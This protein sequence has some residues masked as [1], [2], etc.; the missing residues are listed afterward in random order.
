MVSGNETPSCM[1]M[2][3]ESD[4][5]AR[6]SYESGRK[7]RR[8]KGREADKERRKQDGKGDQDYKGFGAKDDTMAAAKEFKKRP[9]NEVPSYGFAVRQL[10]KRDMLPAI[11]FIFS[12]MRTLSYMHIHMHACI[13]KYIHT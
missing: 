7:G 1:C 13:H 4:G 12:R 3:R 10:K 8:K 5:K 9:K 6:R 2:Q 11:V